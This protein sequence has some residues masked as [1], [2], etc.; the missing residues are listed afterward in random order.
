MIYPLDN[1]IDLSNNLN[2]FYFTLDESS[3]A[4]KKE[5]HTVVQFLYEARKDLSVYIV[6][7]R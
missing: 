4:D 5:K 2:Q 3:L 7:L 6:N 1:L